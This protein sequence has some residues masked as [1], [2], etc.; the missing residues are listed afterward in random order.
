MRVGRGVLAALAF[1][2]VV[3]FHPH[4]DPLP[5]RERGDDSA[6]IFHVIVCRSVRAVGV[7]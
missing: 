6:D 3:R 5:S 4:P 2:L 7:I 1:Y